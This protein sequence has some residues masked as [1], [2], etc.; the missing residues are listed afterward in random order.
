[1]ETEVVADEGVVPYEPPTH[2]EGQRTKRIKGRKDAKYSYADRIAVECCM[3]DNCRTSRSL[4]LDVAVHGPRA[5][6]FF[7]GAWLRRAPDMPRDKHFGYR[8]LRAE[9]RAYAESL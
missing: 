6:E 9:V 5:A 1:M 2:I 4:A 7:L 8:P 3:H